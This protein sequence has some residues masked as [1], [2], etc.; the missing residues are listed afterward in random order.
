MES[1]LGSIQTS[2]VTN[3]TMVIKASI[4]TSGSVVRYQYKTLHKMNHYKM[5]LKIVILK[6][7]NSFIT[8]F[9]S[10]CINRK[11]YNMKPK[12]NSEI[13]KLKKVFSEAFV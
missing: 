12:L 11:N 1:L 3:N 9:K 5:N 4:G 2:L 7:I 13:K 6:Y 8:L 10:T